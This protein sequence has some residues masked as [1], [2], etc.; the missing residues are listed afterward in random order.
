MTKETK[1]PA[2]KTRV[3]NNKKV[4]VPKPSKVKKA[5]KAKSKRLARLPKYMTDKASLKHYRFALKYV[6]LEL[7]GTQAYLAVYGEGY[8]L[9]KGK[10]MSDKVAANSA[11]VLLNKPEIQQHVRDIVTELLH[12]D[13]MNAKTIISKYSRWSNANIADYMDWDMVEWVD[14]EGN[15]HVNVRPTVIP[16]SEIPEELQQ[17]IK[18]VSFTKDGFKFELVDKKGSNDQLAK[19]AG[20]DKGEKD[21]EREI[22]IHFDQYDEQL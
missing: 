4:P 5:I 15:S 6:E 19:L 9:L 3:G 17:N 7:N 18:S 14:E 21:L 11:M 13:K 20:L 8:K 2:K 12:E 22:H 10:K 1:K 16:L